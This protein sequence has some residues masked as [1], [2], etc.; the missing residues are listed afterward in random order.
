VRYG[1]PPVPSTY[2]CNAKVNLILF[3]SY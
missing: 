1:P 2:V 3:N